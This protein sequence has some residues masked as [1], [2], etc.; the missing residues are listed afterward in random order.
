M[1]LTEE[2]FAEVL[3]KRPQKPTP[4]LPKARARRRRHTP[5]K[6]NTYERQYAEQVLDPQKLA[7]EVLEYWFERFT[8]KLADDCRY[9][10]DFVV[11]LADATLEIRE[12]KGRW[13]DDALV[14]IKVASEMFSI[15]TFIAIQRLT[16]KEGGGWKIR[17]FSENY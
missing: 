5:G 10:P 14:K 9:T 1:R 12:V 11:M 7:G 2:Q 6:M 13:E 15:F 4:K 8:F 17:D 16:K 3:S